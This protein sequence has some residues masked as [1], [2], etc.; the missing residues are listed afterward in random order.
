MEDKKLRV[1]ITT[2]IPAPYMINY[3]SELGKKTDLTA[4]FEIDRAKD[5]EA[6]WYG[7]ENKYFKAVFLRGIPC[8]DE[9]GFSLKIIKYLSTKTFDRII[10][11]NPT[12]PTG[13]V[14]LL[15]CRWFRIPFVIQSEGGFQ[16]SG[17]GFK[18]KFKKYLMK[19]AEFYLTGMGGNNDYF[20]LYGAK[21]DT[22]YKYPFASFFA[23]DV[24]RT[25]LSIEAKADIRSKL[26]IAEKKV[27]ISVGRIIHG[28]GHDTL[29]EAVNKLP[30]DVGVYIIGG[31]ATT[32]LQARVDCYG[33][34]NVHFVDFVP[35]PILWEYYKM[36]DILTVPT[37]GDTWGLFVNEA[38]ANG[39]PI[40]TTDKCIAGLELI[41]NGENGYLIHVDDAD[42]LAS[43]ITE[44]LANEALRSKM[45][46]NNLDK[47]QGYT[48]EQ[49]AKTI[50]NVLENTSKMANTAQKGEVQ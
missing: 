45:A 2:N 41:E 17:K 46:Y 11:A 21:E 4:L 34:T 31:E 30:R 22:L 40:I 32:E 10:I 39:L 42:T 1:L 28:K 9:T 12:T 16:G 37:R 20:L 24:L 8:G 36:A 35:K 6:S 44:L 23:E 7:N 19:K 26:G 50:L 25:P 48:F 43:R 27:I 18:E 15:Y 3:L 33:L 13:I 47:I 49:Q 14:A 29:I 5:R 38:M